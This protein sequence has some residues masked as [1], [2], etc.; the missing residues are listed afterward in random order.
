MHAFNPSIWE[1]E[2]GG[3]L[4]SRPACFTEWVPGQ[5]GLH[6]E[7]LSPKAYTYIHTYIHIY[8]YIYCYSYSPYV[9]EV[10]TG[11]IRE[12]NQRA[13]NRNRKQGVICRW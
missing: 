1:A 8:I 5:P 10:L 6:R 13:T 11:D 2:T 4:N 12:R 7:T 3:F 9:F